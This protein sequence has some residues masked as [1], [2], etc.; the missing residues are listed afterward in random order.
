M[1]I[2]RWLRLLRAPHSQKQAEDI[3]GQVVFLSGS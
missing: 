3:A 1:S 2:G